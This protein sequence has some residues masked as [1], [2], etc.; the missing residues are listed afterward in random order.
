MFEDSEFFAEVEHSPGDGEHPLWIT[1]SAVALIDVFQN[2]AELNDAGES[3]DG[4]AVDAVNDLAA[5]IRGSTDREKA[6]IG[7]YLL[8]ALVRAAGDDS[9]GTACDALRALR[10]RAAE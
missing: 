10:R 4:A 3:T 6:L 2:Y 8:G 5:L 1:L 7:G 9:D